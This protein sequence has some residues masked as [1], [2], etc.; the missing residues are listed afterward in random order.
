MMPASTL[1]NAE[2]FRTGRDADMREAG[3]VNVKGNC[4]KFVFEAMSLHFLRFFILSSPPRTLEH[5][6]AL[7]LPFCRDGD[8]G[9]RKSASI[10]SRLLAGMRQ[11][12]VAPLSAASAS[13]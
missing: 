13:S 6:R 8:G 12:S 10:T 1:T 5:T 4:D 9:S 2:Q 3:H 11:G 7:S